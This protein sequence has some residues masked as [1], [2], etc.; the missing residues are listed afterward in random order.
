M[1]FWSSAALCFT[2]TWLG[3]HILHTALHLIPTHQSRPRNRTTQQD[4]FYFYINKG[5]CADITVSTKSYSPHLETTFIPNK[6][7]HSQWEFAL[8]IL[9]SLHPISSHLADNIT[10]MEHNRPE[11]VGRLWT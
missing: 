3:K 11:A 2:K 6:Q 1:D 10:N 4:G 9:L 8:L 7:F 5:R